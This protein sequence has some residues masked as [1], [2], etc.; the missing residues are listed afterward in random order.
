M[1]D[2]TEN[3]ISDVLGGDG[4]V[5]GRKRCSEDGVKRMMEGRQKYR[6]GDE[7]RKQ[8]RS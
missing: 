1:L 5:D 2:V 6:R 4:I 8:D 7:E 3:G